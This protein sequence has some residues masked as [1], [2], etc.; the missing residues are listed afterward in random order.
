LTAVGAVRTAAALERA[1]VGGQNATLPINK[2]V[3]IVTNRGEQ[4]TGRRLNEDTFTVQV[5]DEQQRL[6]SFDKTTLR[7]LTVLDEPLMPSYADAFD[8][9]ERADIVSYLLTLKGTAR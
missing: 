9:R 3:R 5:V 1:L 7:E 4:V 8:E 2:P 6:R